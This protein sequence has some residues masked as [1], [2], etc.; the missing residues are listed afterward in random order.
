MKVFLTGGTGFIGSRVVTRL[1]EAGHDPRCL[2]RSAP[3]AGP[4]AGRGIRRIRGDL[5]DRAALREGMAGCDCVIHLAAAYSFWMANRR[6]FREVNVDGT[7][8]VRECALETGVPK[9]VMVSTVVTYGHRAERPVTEETP[10]GP[11]RFSEYARTKYQGERI[12]WDLHESRGLPLVTVYPG[13]VLG[14]F[15]PKPTGEYIQAMIAGRMP[16]RIL[17]DATFPFV[18]VGD[19]AK[20]VVRAAERADN[21]GARYFLVG[22]NL[23]FGQINRMIAEISNVPLPAWRLPTPLVVALA[24]LL[25]RVADLTKKPPAWGLSADQVG[26]L[27]AGTIFSGAKAERELGISYT[28]IRQAIEEAVASYR[29]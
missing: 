23:T 28:P 22:E 20:A 9:V 10:V 8:S 15:D 14:P 21:V 7:R 17:E 29:T 4:A 25:T 13:A 27:R 6:A 3:A 19:V 5:S 24:A 16:A 26:T 18:H 2:V 1:A 12:A 11:A